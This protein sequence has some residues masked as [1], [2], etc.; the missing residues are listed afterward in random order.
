[1]GVL[2]RQLNERLF[3]AVLYG[4]AMLLMPLA[5]RPV[6]QSTPDLSAYE[7][8]DGTLPLLCSPAKGGGSRSRS[9]TVCDACLLTAAPGLIV[10]G[11]AIS[12]PAV[13][14]LAVLDAPYEV[15]SFKKRFDSEARARAPP[16]D[17]A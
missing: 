9:F 6:R 7:L 15:P 10:G 4:L 3:I 1:M 16:T 5:H 17:L 11:P 2:T 13:S 8:P 14:V 12:A